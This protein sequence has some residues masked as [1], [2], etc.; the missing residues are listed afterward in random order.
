MSEWIDCTHVFSN[1]TE[2]EWFMETQCFNG[3]TRYRN[4]K[5][6]VFTAILDAMFDRSRFPFSDLLEHKKY[7]GMRCK[8]RTIEPIKRTKRLPK[9]QGLIWEE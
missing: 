3:C 8:R 4:G 1:G 5:C 2:H 6:R 7:A 9:N